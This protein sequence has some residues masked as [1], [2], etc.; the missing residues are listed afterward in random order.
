MCGLVGDDAVAE[1]PEL[2]RT[3][4]AGVPVTWP[5]RPIIHSTNAADSRRVPGAVGLGAAC[6]VTCS[7]RRM[8]GK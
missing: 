4:E 5:S 2:N 3:G 6:W 8:A 1:E 7:H